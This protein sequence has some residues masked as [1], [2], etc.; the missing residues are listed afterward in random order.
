[1]VQKLKQTLEQLPKGYWSLT[2]TNSSPACETQARPTQ[3]VLC[4]SLG[5][6][7]LLVSTRGAMKHTAGFSCIDNSLL[8]WVKP[9]SSPLQA[10]LLQQAI[11][12]AALEHS[13]RSKPTPKATPP[14][15]QSDG[16]LL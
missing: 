12:A 3:G 6:T 13:I 10:L 5:D 7:D 2:A 16:V 15:A 8:C 11:I 14:P 9:A 4:T 1:M